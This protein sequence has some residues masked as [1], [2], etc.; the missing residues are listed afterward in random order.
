MINNEALRAAQEHNIDFVMS[1]G[2]MDSAPTDESHV[3]AW[4]EFRDYLTDH[5]YPTVA[6]LEND[7]TELKSTYLTCTQDL[8]SLQQTKDAYNATLD[9]MQLKLDRA[10]NNFTFAVQ[11]L[12]IEEQKL[13]SSNLSDDKVGKPGKVRNV[14][15]STS[16]TILTFEEVIKSFHSLHTDLMFDTNMTEIKAAGVHAV[17]NLFMK[18]SLHMQLLRKLCTW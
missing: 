4:R 14:E 5:P 12:Y 17:G 10:R 11:Q 8:A 2:L 18:L 6:T 15:G 3:T 13:K 1:E 9:E 16:E 7:I